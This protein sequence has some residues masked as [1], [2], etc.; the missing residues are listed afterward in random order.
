MQTTRKRN[1]A[2]RTRSGC[3]TCRAR[4]LRCDEGKPNCSNCTRLR[5]QCGGY[6]LQFRFKD[7]TN[8]LKN[9]L[10]RPG[11]SKG[12]LRVAIATSPSLPEETL[13]LASP[14]PT[15]N[16]VTATPA[17]EENDDISQTHG[18]TPNSQQ[19]I[20]YDA[21]T[22][23]S[24]IAGILPDTLD[25]IVLKDRP[26]DVQS[27]ISVLD[28][29][30]GQPA[31][32]ED[33]GQI[34]SIP[35]TPKEPSETN[36]SAT[37]GNGL[38]NSPR[39]QDAA[40]LCLLPTADGQAEAPEI[41]PP[42][43]LETAK[44]AED[45]IYYHHLCD[46]SP[47]GLLSILGLGDILQ[48]DGLDKGFFHAALALSAFHISHSPVS[49]ALASTAAIHALDHFVEALGSRT[50][51]HHVAGYLLLLANF[52]LSRGQ[53][54]LWYVH[55]HAA[56]TYLSQ[57]IVQVGTLPVGE[58]IILS[59]SR[60]AALLEIFDRSYTAHHGLAM[61]NV[62]LLL[63]NSLR[64]SPDPE[65]RLLDILPRVI[66][67]EEECRSSAGLDGH[68]RLQAQGLIDELKAWRQSLDNRDVPSMD[69]LQA[70]P[71]AIKEGESTMTI[72]PLTL[73]R[74]LEPVKAATSFMHYLLSL[75]RLET[76]YFPRVGRQLPANASKL[77][78][79]ACRLAAGVTSSS[80]AAINAYGHGMVPA[81]MN[82]Y[83]LSEDCTAKIWIK[84][85][86]SRFPCDREGIWNVRHA[87]RLLQYVDKEYSQR[88]S[89]LNWEIIKVRMV[90]LEEEGMSQDGDKDADC[91][92]VEIYSRCR[93][94]WSIDFV[95]IP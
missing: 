3:V 72:R 76:K 46:A 5:L 16:D 2:S 37:L 57:N 45:M 29:G 49:P 64:T 87:H 24:L 51:Q 43:L 19:R 66:E 54:K 92:S 8:L 26:A 50:K 56:V 40:E 11:R 14:S 71:W 60:I 44:F 83:Y 34:V 4:R 36:G 27:P 75:V 28:G 21:A 95:D 58:S 55:S 65:D 6:A 31:T 94:G 73:S 42:G 85:W 61:S 22:S 63:G 15:P 53:M 79:V 32:F 12:A 13:A 33:Q 62:S 90:D 84:D 70:D 78:L 67:F 39:L 25:L 89:R 10:D 80:C 35:S 47:H 41:A 93:R 9:K 82:A 59:F 30:L 86:I 69:E 20:L 88:G 18:V 1:V 68:W 7:Q 74:A 77:I 23:L 48:I 91:F 52:E 81:M 38:Q 17:S